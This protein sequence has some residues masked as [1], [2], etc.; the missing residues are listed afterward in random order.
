[1]IKKAMKAA[2]APTA[3]RAPKATKVAKSVDATKVEAAAADEPST[4]AGSAT[5]DRHRIHTVASGFAACSPVIASRK[6]IFRRAPLRCSLEGPRVQCPVSDFRDRS[7]TR[8]RLDFAS[9][10]PDQTGFCKAIEFPDRAVRLPTH[11]LQLSAR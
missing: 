6:L 2:R 8:L 11:N 10:R 4:A 7:V 5:K 9:G 1:M 3:A